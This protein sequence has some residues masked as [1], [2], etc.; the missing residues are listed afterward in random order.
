MLIDDN[1]PCNLFPIYTALKTKHLQKN[2]WKISM[3]KTFQLIVLPFQQL[4][5]DLVNLKLILLT[6]E[7]F[8]VST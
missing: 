2:I 5:P 7:C 6:A 3:S 1:T 4:K 8:N